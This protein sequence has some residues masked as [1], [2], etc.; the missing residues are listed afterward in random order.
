[1]KM[2]LI[3]PDADVSALLTKVALF[4]TPYMGRE[5]SWKLK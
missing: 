4:A 2:P 1:M 3:I 5:F